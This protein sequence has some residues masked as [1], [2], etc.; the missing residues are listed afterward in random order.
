MTWVNL[1][2]DIRELF[3]PPAHHR[4][5]LNRGAALEGCAAITSRLHQRVTV[6]HRRPAVVVMEWRRCP[7]CGARFE[8]RTGRNRVYCERQGVCWRRAYGRLAPKRT[9]APRPTHPCVGCATTLVR[10]NQ[11][12]CDC[13]KRELHRVKMQR[14]RARHKS[15]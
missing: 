7:V 1:E 11:K 6:L 14:L 4:G 10:P 9:P 13:C 8:A 3:E 2:E 15:A 5:L 12:R